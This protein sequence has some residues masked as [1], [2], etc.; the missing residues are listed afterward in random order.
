MKTCNKGQFVSWLDW[1]EQSGYGLIDV[2]FQCSDGTETRMTHNDNG[3]RNYGVH[4]KEGFDEMIAREQ[5]GYGIINVQMSC[6]ESNNFDFSNGNF[7]G[8]N[9]NKQSCKPGFKMVG[10]ETQEQSGYGIINFRFLCQNL[11]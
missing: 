10:I 7:D 8:F 9:N 11:S 4:C 5:P 3:W 6:Y 1:Y 2:K